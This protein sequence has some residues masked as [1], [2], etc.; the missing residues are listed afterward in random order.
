MGTR[1]AVDTLLFGENLTLSTQLIRVAGALFVLSLFAHLPAHYLP[2]LSL[3]GPGVTTAVFLSMFLVAAG[4]AYLNDGALV[5][6]ALASGIGIG[7]YAPAI[8]FHIRNP[9]EVT[10]WVLAVGTLSSV[11]VGVVGFAVGAGAR[12][13]LGE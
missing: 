7:F 8:V 10:L 12:R 1:D 5:A 13:L 9:G 2:F 6:V 11:G 4:A 3:T